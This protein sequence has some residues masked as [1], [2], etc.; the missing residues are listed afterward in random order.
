MKTLKRAM[1]VLSVLAVLACIQPVVERP[2]AP[3]SGVLRVTLAGGSGRTA[4][5]QYNVNSLYYTLVFTATGGPAQAE[6]LG[7][8]SGA[9]NTGASSGTFTL[10][11]GTWSLAVRGFA[12]QA[13]VGDPANALVSG[14]ADNI[15]MSGS[16]GASI[17]VALSPDESKLTQNGTGTLSYNI[18]VPAGVTQGSLA[19]YDN[20]G[21]LVTLGGG[22]S[23]TL[24]AGANTGN[25]TLVSR[26][27]D[28]A[29]KA[30]YGR[31]DRCP[32]GHGPYLR[33]PGNPGGV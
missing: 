16:A 11:A 21:T 33:R 4:L 5:P 19:V 31:Q 1:I 8:V 22:N 29:N 3:E 9:I 23:V 18:T 26:V 14:S 24:S 13:A 30:L 20:T 10:A 17:G 7:P 6:G 27:Y 28:L 2:P 12:S 15:V 32:G 25:I